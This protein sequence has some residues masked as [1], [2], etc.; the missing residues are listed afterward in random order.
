MPDTTDLRPIER[1]ILSMQRAGQGI[2]EIATMLK[3]SPQH[4]ERMIRWIEIPRSGVP[5]KFSG[6]LETR[7]LDLRRQGL[8]HAEIGRRFRR[9]ADNIRQIEAL[10]HYRRALALFRSAVPTDREA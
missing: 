3:R 9:G 4:I 1:R 2:D 10:A 8:D 6:A 7:V 5:Y